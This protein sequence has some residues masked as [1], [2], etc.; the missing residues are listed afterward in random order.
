MLLSF[1]EILTQD[2]EKKPSTTWMRDTQNRI[3]MF[4]GFLRNKEYEIA[5]QKLD[6]WRTF[7]L[8][9]LEL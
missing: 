1:D 8:I 7:T 9:N 5:N 3:I 2:L 6:E 4:L